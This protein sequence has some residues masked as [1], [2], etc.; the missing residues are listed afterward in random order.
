MY[1]KF[2]P[3]DKKMIFYNFTT[4]WKISN[5]REQPPIKLEAGQH[6]H[7]KLYLY[8]SSYYEKWCYGLN[9]SRY[10]DT[11]NMDMGVFEMKNSDKFSCNATTVDKG[12]IPYIM[13]Q[14]T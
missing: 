10:Q 8:S 1:D 2:K 6:F 13:Y 7:L 3:D 5:A 4:D 11:E 14:F 12:C 9:G